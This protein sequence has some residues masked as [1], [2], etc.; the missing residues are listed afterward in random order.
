[1]STRGCGVKVSRLQVPHGT[2]WNDRLTS[3]DLFAG[4]LVSRIGTLS[5]DKQ[6]KLE[7]DA[8]KLEKKAAKKAEAEAKKKEQTKVRHV[9]L[10]S[11]FP[12][13]F[14]YSFFKI[15]CHQALR[16]NKAQASNT[17]PKPRIIRC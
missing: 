11:C 3:A 17:H 4:A 2:P 10:A 9:L 13:R 12:H 14:I 6:E 5:L 15:D 8:A 16:T 7:A 1:M